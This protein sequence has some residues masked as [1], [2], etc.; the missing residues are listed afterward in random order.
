MSNFYEFKV[1]AV[2]TE[3]ETKRML[4]TMLDNV[5]QDYDDDASINDLEDAIKEFASSEWIEHEFTMEMICADPED[6]I[7]SDSA[8]LY[9]NKHKEYYITTFSSTSSYTSHTQDFAKLQR[10]SGI[11]MMS[12][13]SDE[14]V[15]DRDFIFDYGGGFADPDVDYGFE[16]AFVLHCMML[17]PE[18]IEELFDAYGISDEDYKERFTFYV[19]E[20]E[21]ALT[22][23]KWI[24][25]YLDEYSIDEEEDPEEY[26]LDRKYAI[27]MWYLFDLKDSEKYS[28]ALDKAAEEYLK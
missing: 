24:E 6:R 25:K 20:G 26:E 1:V 28:R 12:I 27:A 2:G 17:N 9:F 22:K 19:P 18:L 14:C 4:K 23:D 13:G 3:D 7:T 11:Y 21:K 5:N 8:S 16:A 10:D 15:G